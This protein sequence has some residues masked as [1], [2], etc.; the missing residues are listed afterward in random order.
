VPP[1]SLDAERVSPSDEPSQ[2]D[3]NGRPSW[4]CATC[5]PPR[6]ANWV[7][8]DGRYAT[9]APCYDRLREMLGE[10]TDRYS[11]L[12]PLPGAAGIDEVG[13]GAPLSFESK[14]PGSTH[15]M[16]MRDLRSSQDARVWLGGDGRVHREDERAVLSVPGVLLTL[17]SVVAERRRI[18]VPDDY[19]VHS[20]VGWLDRHVDYVTRHAE[21][22]VPIE[23]AL[24]D[25]VSQL[26]PVTG[27]G[28]RRIGKC[29]N[30]PEGQDERCGAQLYAPL[31]YAGDDEISCFACGRRWPMTEWLTLGDA[32]MARL[33]AFIDEAG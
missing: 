20:L 3:P 32:L 12:N 30:V 13:G 10:V 9:C 21:L 2:H 6:G 5:P 4:A 31:G 11:R 26:R 29:P 33:D 27:D 23:A 1:E 24:R 28:R 15:V 17:A 8:R 19:R 22:A 25:L 16:A 18:R 7:R 14:V